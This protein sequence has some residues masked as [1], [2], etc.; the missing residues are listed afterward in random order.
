[1]SLTPPED[2]VGLTRRVLQLILEREYRVVLITK[3]SLVLRDLDMLQ[4][5]RGR[6]V[7]QITITTL[8]SDLAAVLE[9]G[10]P[11]PSERLEAVR[12]TAAAGVPVSVRLDPLI[13]Y[14]NDDPENV[15][16][17]ISAAARAGASHV[18]VST[19]KA[20]RD[21]FAR[22]ARAFPDLASLWQRLYFIEGTYFH[23]QWYAPKS[24]RAR[25]LGLAASAAEKYGVAL[26]V[27]R[28]GFA[29]LSAPGSRCD[30]S[31]LMPARS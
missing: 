29:H 5:Y 1:M 14:I 9:P 15:E 26:T 3:S 2:R 19:Y 31:H 30:G 4:K 28:E 12:R 23:G 25:V 16:S 7:V 27:C 24:Y 13:P 17:V 21:N 8:K 18:V 6:A 11:R 20:R 22:L 10:A